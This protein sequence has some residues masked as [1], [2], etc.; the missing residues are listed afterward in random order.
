MNRNT[1]NGKQ[2]MFNKQQF[3]NAWAEHIETIKDNVE[4]FK[5]EWE[6]WFKEEN[7]NQQ[8]VG[9]ALTR[10]LLFNYLESEDFE[11]RNAVKEQLKEDFYIVD[12]NVAFDDWA[13]AKILYN[14]ELHFDS[15]GEF[16]ER[17]YNQNL[18]NIKKVIQLIKK[19]GYDDKW[20]IND[21]INAEEKAKFYEIFRI[22]I[23]LFGFPYP[24]SGA[25]ILFLWHYKSDKFQLNIIANLDDKTT[26]YIETYQRSYKKDRRFDNLCKK[27]FINWRK[28]T[29]NR[30]KRGKHKGEMFGKH[31]NL[32][33][34]CSMAYFC[35]LVRPDGCKMI[36]KIVN[37]PYLNPTHPIFTMTKEQALLSLFITML[38]FQLSDDEIIELCI[39]E[40]RMI[41]TYMKI[42]SY[43]NKLDL[44][45]F[46]CNQIEKDN[47]TELGDFSLGMLNTLFDK[48]GF[49]ELIKKLK[50]S[51]A[52][53]NEV[54]DWSE[55]NRC[56]PIYVFLHKTLLYQRLGIFP[57]QYIRKEE[58][59]KKPIGF[60]DGMQY[61]V[62]EGLID[63]GIHLPIEIVDENTCVFQGFY[64]KFKEIISQ[65]FPQQNLENDSCYNRRIEK[66]WSLACKCLVYVFREAFNFNSNFENEH[67]KLNDRWCF[68][69]IK[70]N[71]S[72]SFLLITMMIMDRIQDVKVWD[73]YAR[74]D[75]KI[76]YILNNI[77]KHHS[78]VLLKQI[79]DLYFLFIHNSCC[80]G[81]C[82]ENTLFEALSGI[83]D[84]LL[85]N[86]IMTPSEKI[87]QQE[88]EDFERNLFSFLALPK[89]CRYILKGIQKA[90]Y[91]TLQV[92]EQDNFLGNIFSKQFEHTIRLSDILEKKVGPLTKEDIINEYKE[93]KEYLDIK[94][95]LN[96]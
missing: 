32:D 10:D 66:L 9:Y 62:G 93:Y 68:N 90:L 41:N 82:C 70:G 47:F 7:R 75:L 29:D 49:D 96:M 20:N 55:E 77:K 73:P 60:P 5:S 34:A 42:I 11:L 1:A 57:Y 72:V 52:Y 27:F 53:E 51:F 58:R 69:H 59:E 48:G 37:Q 33:Q 44:A 23:Y 3:D 6:Q 28:G 18:D 36:S 17:E 86:G 13:Y 30:Y 81:N 83:K 87:E 43:I 22:P 61:P 91:Q 67:R 2:G 56:N 63:I 78:D 35:D 88:I 84:F 65:I 74:R 45:I 31:P 95:Y 24:L 16:H 76:S 39:C 85:F 71:T 54:W 89:S 25:Y 26:N 79:Q 4:S 15:C 46:L 64:E 50:Q 80:Y 21:M 8:E 92:I 94:Y 40:P 14:E 38:F 12:Y 19:Y